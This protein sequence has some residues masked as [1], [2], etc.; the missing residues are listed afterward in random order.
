[1]KKAGIILIAF[2]LIAGGC[3]QSDNKVTITPIDFELDYVPVSKMMYYEVSNYEQL[4]KEELLKVLEDYV[5]LNCSENEIKQY[6]WYYLCFYKKSFWVDYRKYLEEKRSRQDEFPIISE[7]KHNNI[8]L[9]YY[10]KLDK[11]S[12]MW[13]YRRILYDRKLYGDNS[14]IALEKRDTVKISDEN[15]ISAIDAKFPL[16]LTEIEF[17][18]KNNT[19]Q[20]NDEI[21]S[22]IKKTIE[23]YANEDKIY[24]NTQIYNDIYVNTIRL[25]DSLQTVFFVL[26]KT[27]PFTNVHSKVL[28]YDNR[29][30]IF[31]DETFNFK[32][33]ALYNFE[34]G[35]L[36]PSELKEY[37]KI[38][39]PEI[40]LVDYDKD[41][42]ND[43]KF[44]RLWH[45][46]TFNA[47]H[48]T[49]LSVKNNKLDTLYFDETPIGNEK[50]QKPARVDLQSVR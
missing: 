12:D 24:D 28:F 32:L 3:G 23:E 31:A 38:T 44:V 37:F 10:N 33:W 34:N 39:S 25:Y 2:A 18:N 7:Q 9:F 22:Q 41:G 17:E 35:M 4:S 27:Y 16:R 48:T 6:Q 47:I 40:E 19:I 49:I 36:V 15:V 43:F 11:H 42:T 13:E 8:V 1:M 14:E 21:I 26:L 30:K 50:F 46:G 20:L 29:K 45:N 5:Q